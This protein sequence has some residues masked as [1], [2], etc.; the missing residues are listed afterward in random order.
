MGF[1]SA[2]GKSFVVVV[3]GGLGIGAVAVASNLI[4]ELVDQ[5][6]LLFLGV[7]AFVLAPALGAFLLAFLLMLAIG[8]PA[9]LFPVL[10]GILALVCSA[11]SL[12][13]T[14]FFIKTCEGGL[15]CLGYLIYYPVLFIVLV[16]LL[17]QVF[18][19]VDA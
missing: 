10:A 6:L 9:G 4:G 17:G 11:F 13:V 1:W 8:R 16:L 5:S 18:A 2:V 15:E 14:G 19:V 7:G 3:G 12:A